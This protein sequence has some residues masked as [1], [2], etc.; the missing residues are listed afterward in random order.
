MAEARHF[1]ALNE[2]NTLRIAPAGAGAIELLMVDDVFAPGHESLTI[3]YAVHRRVM[4][5]RI[6]IFSASHGPEPLAVSRLG[7]TDLTAGS[8]Y[9]VAWDGKVTCEHGELAGRFANPLF[10]PYEVSITFDAGAGEEVTPAR[11]FNVGYHSVELRRAPWT[12]D[13]ALTVSTPGAHEP[14]A[15]RDRRLRYH[16]NEAGFWAGPI[17]EDLDGGLL[18]AVRRFRSQHP[19]FVKGGFLDHPTVIERDVEVE[20]LGHTVTREAIEYAAF[21]DPGVESRIL[22]EELFKERGDGSDQRAAIERRRLTRPAIPVEAVIKLRSKS[23]SGVDAPG[24]VGPVRVE[25][26]IDEVGEDVGSLPLV[27]AEHFPSFTRRYVQKVHDLYDTEE[28]KNCPVEHGGISA[29]DGSWTSA[30]LLGR[31]LPP[32]EVEA[33]ASRKVVWCHA[34]DFEPALAGAHGRAA[35]LFRPS[36]MGG[37]GYRITARLSFSDRS[38]AADLAALHGAVERRTGTFRIWREVPLATRI[39]WPGAKA[40]GRADLERVP[41]EL[42]YA[43]VSLHGKPRDLSIK[44]LLDDESYRRGVEARAVVPIEWF[45]LDERAVYGAPFTKQTTVASE[46]EKE[47]FRQIKP[48][49][50][51]NLAD[52]AW[53]IR[54]A[55]QARGLGYGIHVVEFLHHVP[56]TT[57]VDPPKDNAVDEARKTVLED[58]SR[59]ADNGVPF[60]DITDKAPMFTYSHEIGHELFLD[61]SVPKA[62]DDNGMTA[63]P[64][65][66]DDQ[67]TS[68]IMGDGAFTFRHFCGKCV[69]NLRGW[70]LE[71]LPLSSA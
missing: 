71:G 15:L 67:D 64:E 28:R 22:V 53:E 23:G 6:E 44:D 31:A 13:A 34:A 19:F 52:L 26:R 54:R 60:M 57:L 36:W 68:C 12:Y 16:L 5:A 48:I 40:G 4:A 8:R 11:S 55:A 2:V 70:K 59:A 25:F 62:G 39:A 45:E 69:L 7:P 56:F 29:E 51:D 27:P 14:Q 3:A 66:H 1:V 18:N 47:V 65:H 32:F 50:G 9:T 10:A 30:A 42:E 41:K 21:E 35:F 58:V 20:I 61:H 46:Y 38:N 33:D 43:F 24:A 63:S 37:D 17:E 49:F